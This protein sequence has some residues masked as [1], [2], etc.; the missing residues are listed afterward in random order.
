MRDQ[1][2]V[3]AVCQRE[4]KAFDAAKLADGL[5]FYLKLRSALPAE[6]AE[7]KLFSLPATTLAAEEFLPGHRD[8]KLYL[9]HDA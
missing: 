7:Q 4:W 6:Y 5:A 1:A 9:R 3:L 8:R 2:G